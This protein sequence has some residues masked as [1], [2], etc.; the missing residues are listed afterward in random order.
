MKRTTITGTAIAALGLAACGSTVAPRVTPTPAP[1]VTSTP[2]PTATAVPNSI[3]HSRAAV[4]DRLVAS[5]GECQRLR[6]HG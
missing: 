1:T 2:A 5:R 3:T 4:A 6:G